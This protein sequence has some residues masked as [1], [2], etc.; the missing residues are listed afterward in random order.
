MNLD[1]MATSFRSVSEGSYQF[2]TFLH[3]PHIPYS[4]VEALLCSFTTVYIYSS[5]ILK[6][7]KLSAFPP[8]PSQMP[9]VSLRYMLIMDK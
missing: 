8:I 2:P 7:P 5:F 4:L 6:T 9:A 3:H 1:V